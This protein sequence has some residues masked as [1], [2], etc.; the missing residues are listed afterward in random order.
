MQLTVQARLKKEALQKA[1][2][3]A[4]KEKALG[5]RNRLSAVQEMNKK[6]TLLEKA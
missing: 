5:V 4:K 1:K 6:M 3:S 2:D